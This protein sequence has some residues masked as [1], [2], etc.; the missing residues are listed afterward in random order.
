M[1]GRAAQSGRHSGRWR[2]CRRAWTSRSGRFPEVQL[3]QHNAARKTGLQHVVALCS[4][5]RDALCSAVLVW[6]RGRV[7]SLPG[8][9]SAGRVSSSGSAAQL[10]PQTVGAAPVQVQGTCA[11]KVSVW[12]Q[13]R[14]CVLQAGWG[15]RPDRCRLRRPAMTGG[16]CWGCGLFCC[17]SAGSLDICRT[18]TRPA[19]R[20][21]HEG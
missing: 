3:L 4:V 14:D 11:C 19:G 6:T 8:R 9:S 18:C 1:A 17:T 5:A 21:S 15:R 16:H 12:Q 2:C 20:G 13:H 10:Q 7:V